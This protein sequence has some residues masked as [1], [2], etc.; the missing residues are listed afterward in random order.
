MFGDHIKMSEIRT[1]SYRKFSVKIVFL[2]W[3]MGYFL[4]HQDIKIVNPDKKIDFPAAA[5][6]GLKRSWYTLFSQ[7]REMDNY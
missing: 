1:K 2:S 5:G 6:V 7:D 3:K 4:I